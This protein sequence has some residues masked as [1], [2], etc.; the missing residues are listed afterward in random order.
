MLDR[1]HICDVLPKLAGFAPRTTT[2][3]PLGSNNS[4]VEVLVDKFPSNSTVISIGLDEGVMD[5]KNEEK[6]FPPIGMYST[7]WCSIVD[8]QPSPFTKFVTS[9]FPSIA[10]S[11]PL[12]FHAHV[13]PMASYMRKEMD[14]R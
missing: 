4:D 5:E 7:S 10:R 13:A 1:R 11:I 2:L 12:L 9:K 6:N 8:E 3:P 14:T